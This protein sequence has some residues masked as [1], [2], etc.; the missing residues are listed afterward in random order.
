VSTAGYLHDYAADDRG[1][2]V[3][4]EFVMNYVAAAMFDEA[5]AQRLV[6]VLTS[7]GFCVEALDYTC[8]LQVNS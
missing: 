2:V 5:C 3:A 6:L 1:K 7:S 4:A 8:V